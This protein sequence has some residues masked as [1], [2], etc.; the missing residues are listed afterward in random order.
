M[1]SNPLILFLRLSRP[2][3]LAG[4]V[5]FYF[6]GV[7]IA[8][9]LGLAL[10][11]AVVLAGQ[12][13]VSAM[14]LC[15][16]YLNEYFDHPQDAGH[17][18]R[19]PFNGGSG[20]L[21]LGEGQ[22]RPPVA[23]V[24]AGTALALVA[25]ATNGLAR[26]GVLTPTLLALL[27]CIF[28]AA[29]F[30]SVP[31]LRLATSGYGELS[32]S[33]LLAALVPALGFAL[34]SGGL[35]RLLGLSTFPLVA[36]TL[37]SLLTLE[38]ADYAQDLRTGK[39][40]LFVRIG[41]EQALRLHHMLVAAGYAMLLGSVAAGLPAAIGLL[42]LLSAPLAGLQIWYMQ[43]IAQGL[44]PN[45]LALTFNGLA[46]TFLAAYLLAQGFWTR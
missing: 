8:R 44:K 7:G 40:T 34:Q 11:W 26:G 36:L 19:T 20:V 27:A 9:Y 35:H 38:F 24:A 30:Y 29:F 4:G 45:W 37:A 31:P 21:G 42:P 10:D 22:L 16:H 32:T 13:W 14:Q 23:L 2:L 15:V 3:Y 46:F 39:R 25:A 6:L 17:S 41:W 43:R 33:F 1:K 5:L 28:F 12:L 18:A